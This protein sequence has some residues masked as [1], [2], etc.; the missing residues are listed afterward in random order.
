MNKKLLLTS[1][2][3]LGVIGAGT[4]TYGSLA[5]M[6]KV[7]GETAQTQQEVSSPEVSSSVINSELG[8]R[9]DILQKLKFLQMKR[10]KLQMPQKTQ[11]KLLNLLKPKKIKY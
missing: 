5:S 2:L 8:K 6:H 4:V 1:F 9:H 10:L 7:A 11:T 3:T